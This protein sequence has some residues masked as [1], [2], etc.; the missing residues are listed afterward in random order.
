MSNDKTEALP[1][2][3]HEM[4]RFVEGGWSVSAE[5]VKDWAFQVRRMHNA[6]AAAPQAPQQCNDN[7]SPWLVCKPCAANGACAMASPQ[8]PAEQRSHYCAEC[9]RLGRELAALKAA[10]QEPQEPVERNNPISAL[11]IRL[12]VAAG[13]VTQEKADEAFRI[14]C[15][16]V[17]EEARRMNVE[18]PWIA[19]PPQ[20]AEPMQALTDEQADAAIAETG[21][22][23][24]ADGAPLN[25]TVLRQ[26]C[27]RAHGITTKEQP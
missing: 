7:D 14:A 25:R 6:L 26:L 4:M 12:L 2:L 9:E 24:L 11:A 13:H 23:Y 3:W 18:L 21:L 20:S 27:K 1:P 17:E 15:Y 19:T 8:A 10:Q 16:C 22:D 5:R